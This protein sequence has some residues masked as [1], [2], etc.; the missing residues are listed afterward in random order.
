MNVAQ[1]EAIAKTVPG[2][3]HVVIWRVSSAWTETFRS[4]I[5]LLA[6]RNR[7]L[8]QDLHPALQYLLLET[9]REI[10]GHRAPLIVSVNS[11]LN[12]P[13]V[14]LS[15]GTSV[16][17]IGPD[18]LAAVHVLLAYLA[19]QP[20]R[21]LRHSGRRDADSHHWLRAS[22]LQMAVRSSCRPIAPGFGKART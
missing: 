4:D 3:K 19:P 18:L 1:A 21:V 11:L 14:L 15:N 13:A 10:P 2:L 17:P 16:L 5:D 7:L 22:L 9:M 8:V 6:L 20:D 12:N